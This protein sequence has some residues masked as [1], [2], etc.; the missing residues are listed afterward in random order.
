VKTEIEH[1]LKV[2]SIEL[3]PLDAW[4]L[5]SSSVNNNPVH[6][7]VKTEAMSIGFGLFRESGPEESEEIVVIALLAAT[8][9]SHAERILELEHK[10]QP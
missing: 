2:N 1:I 8:L 3:T 10:D 7:A 5:V 4:E 9:R 6:V